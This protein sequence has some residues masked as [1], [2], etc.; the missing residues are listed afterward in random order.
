[1]YQAAGPSPADAG[2][3][4][5]VL[6]FE[7]P[8]GFVELPLRTAALA[9]EYGR[10][11]ARSVPGVRVRP[12]EITTG[13]PVSPGP[14]AA[15]GG[16]VIGRNDAWVDGVPLQLTR[17][18][19]GL[20]RYL[21]ERRGRVVSRHQLMVQ[22]WR[23]P[24]VSARTVDTH[25][26]RLRTKLGHYARALRTVRGTGYRWDSADLTELPGHSVTVTGP[27][28]LH[29]DTVGLPAAAHPRPLAT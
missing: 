17:R 9:D 4:R 6:T 26:R 7:V 12:A 13:S 24:Q 2:T 21:A 11:I 22:V 27:T 23:D 29:T 5:V 25:V 19:S 3:V 15:S 14:A 20:L 8:A 28:A 1:M 18:E 16:L 10:I